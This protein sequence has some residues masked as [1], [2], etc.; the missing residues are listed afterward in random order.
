M[1]KKKLEYTK[2]LLDDLK[3]FKI[4]DIQSTEKKNVEEIKKVICKDELLKF[5]KI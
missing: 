1:K 4:E 2:E 3:N 5:F